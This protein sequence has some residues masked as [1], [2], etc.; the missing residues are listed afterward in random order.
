L[1]DEMIMDAMPMAAMAEG[2][3]GASPPRME[4]MAMRAAIMK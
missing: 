3:G 4:R 2:D 1:E